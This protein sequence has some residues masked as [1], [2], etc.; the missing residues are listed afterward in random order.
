MFGI[1]ITVRLENKIST[2]REKNP[3]PVGG[4]IA[5][6][7]GRAGENGYFFFHDA[8]SVSGQY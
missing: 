5:Q 6:V 8:D 4:F 1:S 2:D 3:R 7:R